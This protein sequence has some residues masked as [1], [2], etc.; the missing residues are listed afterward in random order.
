MDDIVKFG[1]VRF[2]VLKIVTSQS[3][4]PSDLSPQNLEGNASTTQLRET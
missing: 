4:E 1:R 3:F 2:K